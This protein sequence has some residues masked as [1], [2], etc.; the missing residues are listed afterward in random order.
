MARHPRDRR[1]RNRCRRCRGGPRSRPRPSEP[2]NGGYDEVAGSGLKDTACLA[3]PDYLG[4]D[5]CP[6]FARRRRPARPT[7]CPGV[8]ACRAIPF[9]SAN[10]S[11]PGPVSWPSGD[12]SSWRSPPYG[13]GTSR[14]CGA[15][16]T[17]WRI[18]VTALA[19]AHS[20]MGTDSRPVLMGGGVLVTCSLA[21]CWRRP[22]PRARLTSA[23][24]ERPTPSA[25]TTIIAPSM[26]PTE[27][28]RTLDRVDA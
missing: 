15:G 26:T 28:G 16:S 22:S 21:V 24:G 8:R 9:A 12:S 10:G 6:R 27:K 2:T 4:R 5:R 3:P 7:P 23:G 20:L 19:V 14:G 11:P 17:T 18:P 25:T 13:G 1:R